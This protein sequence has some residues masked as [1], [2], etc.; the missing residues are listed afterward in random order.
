[1]APETG[2]NQI[3]RK[4]IRRSFPRLRQRIVTIGW[5]G[6]EELLYY[7]AYAD[8]N[9]IVVNNWLRGANRRVFEGGIAHELCHIDADLRLG[10]FQRQLAWERYS[11]SRWYRMREERSTERRVIELGYGECLLELIR[12]ARRLGYSFER[13]H[14]L[15]YA[16]VLRAEALRACKRWRSSSRRSL[17]A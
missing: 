2:L 7:T 11:Q 9:M 16:E 12:F 14:G 10:V 13:E 4:L 8:R 3:L 17:A 15:L 6:G 1:M 5:G